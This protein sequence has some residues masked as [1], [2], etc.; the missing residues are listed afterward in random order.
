MGAVDRTA[1]AAAKVARHHALSR[2]RRAARA[3]LGFVA[4]VPAAEKAEGR[5]HR[6]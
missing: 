2:F 1:I 6:A 5:W 4:E 3:Y